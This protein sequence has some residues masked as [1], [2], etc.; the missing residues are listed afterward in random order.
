MLSHLFL[1]SKTKADVNKH[2]TGPINIASVARSS[3]RQ[4][5][6][7][8]LLGVVSVLVDV[9]QRADE[10]GPLVVPWNRGLLWGGGAQ[11]NNLNTIWKNTGF[12]SGTGSQTML[13]VLIYE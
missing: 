11:Q 7:G 3:G 12:C 6:S 5:L 2:A 1:P 8:Q 9:G 13:C 10:A 4:A